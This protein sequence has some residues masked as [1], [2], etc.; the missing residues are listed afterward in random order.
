MCSPAHPEPSSCAKIVPL[1]VREGA[2]TTDRQQRGALL[3][4][5]MNIIARDFDCRID[6][7][8]RH[9]TICGDLISDPPRCRA[10]LG[11]FRSL[12]I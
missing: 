1:E 8:R 5:Q 7:G 3:I 6:S 2:M 11:Y 12:K 9:S 4:I 10:V